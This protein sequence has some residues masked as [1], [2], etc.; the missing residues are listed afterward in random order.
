MALWDGYG[1]FGDNDTLSAIAAGMV[2][3]DYLF[4]LTDVDCLYTGN[5]RTCP[6]AQP[7]R[8]VDN[9]SRLRENSMIIIV[10]ILIH[11]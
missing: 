7:V 6:T 3:A 4:L 10:C 2:D 1:R 11:S 9:I 8:V 5:P